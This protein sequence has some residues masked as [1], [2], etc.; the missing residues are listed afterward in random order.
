MT[1]HHFS[2]NSFIPRHF[3]EKSGARF[4][5]S[6]SLKSGGGF[7]LTE[8][9]VA[10]TIFV[11]IIVAVYS[12]HT[13]SH[14]AYQEGERAAEITQNGRVILERMTREIRQAKE[15]ITELPDDETGATST[16]MFQDG[17][18]IS[19]I[20][21]IRYF[22][23]GTNIKREEVA[24]YFSDDPSTYVLWNARDE[25]NDPPG[26]PDSCDFEECPDCPPTC[27]ILEG[28]RIIGEYVNSLKLWGPP[29]INIFL[30]LEKNDKTID[31]KTKIL[32]RNL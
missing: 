16:I 29:L 7:T 31:L 22:K 1:P 17:H 32:G 23:D 11:L 2:Y 30:A 18:D 14:R 28:P 24:Y 3:W 19:T 6:Y 9:I 13:L 5:R 20:R 26:G 8:M 4:G 12:A 10:I 25:N 27:K 15:I 21:Y